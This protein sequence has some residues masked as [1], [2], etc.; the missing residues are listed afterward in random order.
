MEMLVLWGVIN[1]RPESWKGC[2]LEK[3]DQFESVPKSDSMIHIEN[4]RKKSV[5]EGCG[6]DLAYVNMEHYNPK[7]DTKRRPINPGIFK[8]IYGNHGIEIIAINYQ[9]DTILQGYIY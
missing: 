3:C 1:I 2:L 5:N 7:K 9:S 6:I 8:G 4:Y